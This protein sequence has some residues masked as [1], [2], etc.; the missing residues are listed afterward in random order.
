MSGKASGIKVTHWRTLS[1]KTYQK[2][3]LSNFFSP[4][5]LKPKDFNIEVKGA[6]LASAGNAPSPLLVFHCLLHLYTFTVP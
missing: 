5:L 2:V 6:P 1:P 4:Y 3:L